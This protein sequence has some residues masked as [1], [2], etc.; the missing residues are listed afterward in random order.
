M[1]YIIP[2]TVKSLEQ[3]KKTISVHVDRAKDKVLIET[4]DIGWFVLFEGSQESLFVGFEKPED[5]V[6]GSKVKIIIDTN[7]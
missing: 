5:L 4:V 2:T 3:K 1:R 6:P 7:D